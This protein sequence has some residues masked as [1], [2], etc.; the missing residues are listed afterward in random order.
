MKSLVTAVV[1][2]HDQPD[3]LSVTL[4]ALANQ[5]SA[6]ARVVILDSSTEGACQ[7]VAADFSEFE[8]RQISADA[9]FKEIIDSFIDTELASDSLSA[10]I[11]LLHDDAAPEKNALQELLQ[12]VERS[13]SAALVGPKQL[14]WQ[15]PREILQLGVTLAPNGDLV[16]LVAGELDQAQHDSLDDVL[17]VGTAGV[18]LKT[19]VYQQLGGL[20]AKAPPL[21]ADVD[22]SIRARLAGFRVL[23]AP[24]AKVIHAAL[25]MNGQRPR[26]WLRVSPKAAVRRA[27]IHLKLTYSS[28]LSAFFYWFFLPA[29]ALGRSI[30]A[31]VAKRPDRIVPEIGASIWGWFTIFSR[32]SG[33]RRVAKNRT[34]AF[35]KLS[36]LRANWRQVRESR[37]AQAD[38]AAF[39]ELPDQ[40]SAGA[41]KVE[42]QL[43]GHGLFESKSIFIALALLILSISWWP[44]GTAAVGGGL[45]PLGQNWI[46]IFNRAGASYQHIGL[47]FLAPSDP[48]VWV[49]TAISALTFWAPSLSIAVLLLLVKPLAFIAF[50]KLASSVTRS[51]LAK[52]LSALVYALWPVALEYQN[53]SRLPILIA[54]MALP[55]FAHAVIRVAGFD[56]RS[57]R[58]SAQQRVTWVAL[59]GLLLAA[60]TASAPIAGVIS[61]A[62]LGLVALTRIK[63]IGYLIWV[64]LPT[65]ALFGPSFIFYSFKLLQ[66]LALLADP[67]LPQQTAQEPFVDLRFAALGSIDASWFLFALVLL[68]LP[69]IFVRRAGV[70]TTLTISSFILIALAVLISRVQVPAVGV[71]STG[72]QHQT[73]FLTEGNALI[74]VALLTG[75]IFAI[76][77]GDL[78][79]KRFKAIYSGLLSLGLVAPA[80]VFTYTNPNPLTYTDARAVPSIVQAEAQAGSQLKLLSLSPIA[81]NNGKVTYAAE[82]V[83]GDGVQLEDV[84][85]S[86]RFAVA[87]I[88]ADSTEFAK[89]SQ[90][91]ADLASASGANIQSSLDSLGLGFILVPKSDSTETAELSFALDSV[92][93]LESVGVTDYGQ[94]WRVREPNQKLLNAKPES[95]ADWSITKGVQLSILA[96]FVLL[97]LPSRTPGRR[98]ADDTA[99]FVDANEEAE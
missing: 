98:R 48:F 88:T 38:A 21:A 32:L 56:Q 97:A 79:A 46:D 77:F 28:P 75:L 92:A 52:N 14:D 95:T 76:F 86:Y 42:D 34:L 36:S 41:G 19:D 33:R 94:L 1:V 70:V 80:V 58:A 31:L 54:Y 35:S 23:V 99:I 44:R 96:A 40:E 20:D 30:A 26:G 24:R 39:I 73:V 85:V 16:T 10:W 78:K 47:G 71:G 5:T 84:S 65:A 11:W 66:P 51:T 67:G 29:L 55:W 18:L 57:D 12:V 17:A 53:E 9:N 4:Q 74:F 22:Y 91:V 6:P 61:L 59:A 37:R 15:N 43:R 60:I 50:Y 2:A 83:N 90:L 69:A 63:R 3:Y 27:E 25:S 89:V 8:Y 64:A 82:L 72:Y 87:Q 62:G 45:L 68:A 13:P 7:Q 49:L 81:S 93:E